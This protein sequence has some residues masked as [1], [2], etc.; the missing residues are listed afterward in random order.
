MNLLV[1]VIVVAVLAIVA[2][3]NPLVQ[4]HFNPAVA[5]QLKLA[6]KIED[7]LKVASEKMFKFAQENP[8]PEEF[9]F[10]DVPMPDDV[11]GADED[12]LRVIHK[13][14]TMNPPVAWLGKD[15][16]VKIESITDLANT[17][18]FHYVFYATVGGGATRK[19]LYTLLDMFTEFYDGIDQ[20]GTLLPDTIAFVNIL[21]VM[22][23]VNYPTTKLS[24]RYVAK[25]DLYKNL[26]AILKTPQRAWVMP[27]LMNFSPTLD[28]KKK[29]MPLVA[30][31]SM[32]NKEV[33]DHQ[34]KEFLENAT[35]HDS[36]QEVYMFMTGLKMFTSDL[37]PTV[38]AWGQPE[39]LKNEHKHV[40]PM[41]ED[42]DGF[43]HTKKV[44]L[45]STNFIMASGKVNLADPNVFVQG[46][47]LLVACHAIECYDKP[48][49]MRMV[50]TFE[51]KMAKVF[52]EF[53][54]PTWKTGGN[55]ADI[56]KGRLPRLMM[57]WAVL[58]KYRDLIP[59]D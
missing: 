32:Y 15:V 39:W 19:H 8:L 41:I 57:A 29:M 34:L 18:M 7:D 12:L 35:R 17:I 58:T 48:S 4:Q 5:H 10:K 53:N 40:L 42:R 27:A 20:Q 33:Q 1:T 28:Q 3:Q 30:K 14:I 59:Y 52:E 37:I 9:E 22:H 21:N 49:E 44:L 25:I 31:T 13:G 55:P 54:L 36:D 2:Y 45:A 38:A 16:N 50:S 23:Q 11:S 56:V 26:E 24:A 47:E 51:R 46:A 43:M 6:K